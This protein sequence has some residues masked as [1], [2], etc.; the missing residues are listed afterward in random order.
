MNDYLTLGFWLAWH[1]SYK[2][3]IV[4]YLY[5]PLGGTRQLAAICIPIFTFVELWRQAFNMGLSCGTTHRAEGGRETG[6][7]SVAGTC[8]LCGPN[9]AYVLFCTA[10]DRWWYHNVCPAGELLNILLVTMIANLVGSSTARGTLRTS[11]SATG[12]GRRRCTANR[13]VLLY[14]HSSA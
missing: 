13:D 2:L 7:L 6:T 9:I 11:L 12:R 5:I 8:P 3:W 14:A 4:C 10:G 1:S